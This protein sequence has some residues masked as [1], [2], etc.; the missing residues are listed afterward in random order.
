MLFIS[1]FS[2][3]SAKFNEFDSGN[4]ILFQIKVFGR[5]IKE[6]TLPR[7]FVKVTV[8]PSFTQLRV[9]RRKNR[10][11][12]ISKQKI[13]Y[14]DSVVSPSHLNLLG[15]IFMLYEILFLLHISYLCYIFYYIFIYY[16]FICILYVFNFC[17]I[18]LFSHY[19]I[20][21]LCYNVSI[22]I[23]CTKML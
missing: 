23:I 16:I 10:I 6:T 9:I 19:L 1:L 20:L 22:F 2:T 13:Y 11:H 7:Y 14:K 3:S 18:F 5:N 21:C 8:R 17:Y 12:W 15:F 4:V